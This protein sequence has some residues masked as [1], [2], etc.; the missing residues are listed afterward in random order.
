MDDVEN[1]ELFFRLNKNNT[2]SF[3]VIIQKYTD[4]ICVYLININEV[5]LKESIFYPNNKIALNG[6]NK[7]NIII[8]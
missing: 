7:E 8:L 5:I 2:I 3:I 1:T 6:F 4:K